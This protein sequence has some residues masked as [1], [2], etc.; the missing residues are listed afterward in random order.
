ME[1]ITADI[2]GLFLL[3]SMLT[4]I[5]LVLIV[6]I[7]VELWNMVFPPD[8]EISCMSKVFHYEYI[9]AVSIL[10]TILFSFIIIVL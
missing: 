1:H 9:I 6:A 4:V 7:L 5:V 8:M 10:L 3:F 2:I